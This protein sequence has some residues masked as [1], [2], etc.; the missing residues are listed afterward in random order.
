MDARVGV[1]A[2]VREWRQSATAEGYSIPLTQAEIIESARNRYK[3][4]ITAVV[5]NKSAAKK[6]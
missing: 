1:S 5:D 4:A 3:A 6:I 2:S